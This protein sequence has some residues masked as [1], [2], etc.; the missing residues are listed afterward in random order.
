MINSV[1]SGAAACMPRK[2][3]QASRLRATVGLLLASLFVISTLVAAGD[4]ALVSQTAEAGSRTLLAALQDPAVQ[5]IVV[6]PA[7]YSVRTEF[8]SYQGKP[9][10]LSR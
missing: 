5:D 9:I 6:L 4:I 3:R 8:E 2:R 10:A 1:A 7:L